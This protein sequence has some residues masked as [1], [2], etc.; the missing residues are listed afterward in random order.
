MVPDS[1]AQPAAEQPYTLASLREFIKANDLSAIASIPVHLLPR[2]LPE[3]FAEEFSPAKRDAVDELFFEA[4]TY[5][6]ERNI[7][8]EKR[9]GQAVFNA[10]EAAKGRTDSGDHLLLKKHIKDLVE[11]YKE[12]RKLPVVEQMGI[13]A[14]KVKQIEGLLEPVQDEMGEAGR[15]RS[16]LARHIDETKN[17]ALDMQ[18]AIDLLDKRFA[19]IEKTLNL[20]YYVRIVMVC[21]EMNRVRDEAKRLTGRARVIQ[22]QLN[23]CREELKRL[24]EQH[25]SLSK[26]EKVR[27]EHLRYQISDYIE[28]MKDYEIMISETSL[29]KWLDIIVEASLSDY[30]NKRAGQSI[31][32]ARLSLFNLLQKYCELQEAAAKQI[33]RNPFAQSDPKKTIEFMLKSEQFILDYFARKKSTMMAWLGGAAEEKVSKLGDLQ[34]ELLKEMQSNRK[35]LH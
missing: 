19:S 16:E 9:F 22:V 23:A 13:Y 12:K 32:A 31:R 30:V 18:Q 5:Q 27:E 11:T 15:G 8:I 14:P 10:I 4:T 26:T 21:D 28:Q 1:T 17:F 3:D 33:A 34:K 25:R 20:Y 29:V 7:E 35:K 24:Q 2:N 6:M